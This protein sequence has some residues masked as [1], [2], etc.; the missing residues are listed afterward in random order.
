MWELMEKQHSRLITP[1]KALCH[2]IFG[3]GKDHKNSAHLPPHPPSN[4]HMS[5]RTSAPDYCPTLLPFSRD[6][7]LTHYWGHQQ[8]LTFRIVLLHWHKLCIPQDFHPVLAPALSQNTE[9]SKLATSFP[10]KL[11]P[12]TRSFE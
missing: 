3:A 8:L 12:H 5:L 1:P 7:E 9:K 4:V 11:P 6:G 10:S 2:D